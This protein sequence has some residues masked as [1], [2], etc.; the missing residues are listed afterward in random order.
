MSLQQ[1]AQHLAAQGRGKDTTLVHMT[2]NEVRG[3]QQIAM[4]AGGSLSVNPSTGLPEAGF[5]E[6]MMPM[7][8]GAGLI[9]ATGGAAAPAVMGMSMPTMIGLGVGGVQALRTGNL[10]EGVK[11]GL[12]AYGGAGLAGG[13]MGAGVGAAQNAAVASAPTSAVGSGLTQQGLANQAAAEATKTALA[14][15]LATAGQ[16]IQGLGTEAGRAG[17]MSSMGGVSGLAKTGLAAAAPMLMTE[18]ED[19]PPITPDKNMGQRYSYSAG[20]TMPFPQ[21]NVPRAGSPEQFQSFGKEQRYFTPGY[22]KIDADQAKSLYGY[23]GGGPV[24]AMSNANAMGANTGYPMADINK[25]AYATPWQ[26]PIPRNVVN[27]AADTNVDPMTGEMKFAEGGEVA[28]K[29]DPGM[30]QYA[31]IK[32]GQSRSPTTQELVNASVGS[33]RV[34]SGGGGGGQGGAA[35]SS[36]SSGYGDFGLGAI[37]AGQALSSYGDILGGLAPGGMLAGLIGAG[38]MSSGTGQLGQA[39]NAAA[40]MGGDFSGH[41]GLDAGSFGYGG[42]MGSGADTSGGYGGSAAGDAAS[43]GYGGDAG[44]GGGGGGGGGGGDGGGGEA[45]GGLMHAYAAGGGYNLGD[46]SD[47]GRLLR[48]PGDGVSDSIP[49]TIGKKQP[50]RLADGEFVVPARIVSELGNGS[51]EAGAR[52]LY[53][54]MNRIQSARGKTVGKGKVAKNSRAERH[55][56]A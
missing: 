10:M 12:G 17:F 37:G 2:P 42:G 11:A 39:E 53:A 33:G 19:P 3:L 4:A 31:A 21:P 40:S 8:I 55:L 27:G 32:Q 25:G 9:A 41:A 52:K 23:A 24:E 7:I 45:N 51:T 43:G 35:G 26:T 14:N 1:A 47:G 56:P 13:L 22:T 44:D 6:D 30:Q 36:G 20:P 16:G 18:P 5:L 29:Y 38:L 49:A 15:P 46:Y 50:A 34:D 48:G 54:M 28:F